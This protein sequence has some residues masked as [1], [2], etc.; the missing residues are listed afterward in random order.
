MSKKKKFLYI[1]QRLGI[2]RHT[3]IIMYKNNKQAKHAIAGEEI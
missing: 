3:D 2:Y 1:M